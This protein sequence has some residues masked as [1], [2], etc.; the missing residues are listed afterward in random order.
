MTADAGSAFPV[1]FFTN[2]QMHAI[3]WILLALLLFGLI[4]GWCLGLVKQGISLAGFLI[5]LIVAKMCYIAVG[6]ALAPHLD[7]HTAFAHVL[8]FVLIWVAVPLALSLLGELF[9][10]V[11]DKLFVLGKVNK[12]LGALLG[13]FKFQLILGSVLWVLCSIKV[14]DA[15]MQQQSV[16]CEPL[17]A[18][19]EALYTA[20]INNG[21][22]E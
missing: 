11:L 16:L 2:E 21:R 20:L 18:V 3:D 9:T 14:I 12:G 7:N 13:L 19:P 1:M 22:E 10:T 5:G 8:S 17:K 4:R 6:D 15:S